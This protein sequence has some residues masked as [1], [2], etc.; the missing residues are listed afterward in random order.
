MRVEGN[1]RMSRLGVVRKDSGMPALEESQPRGRPCKSI[2]VVGVSTSSPGD[3][4]RILG[5]TKE[6]E[7]SSTLLG[8]NF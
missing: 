6:G 5:Y 8:L 2:A 3:R 4:H 7:N 1:P